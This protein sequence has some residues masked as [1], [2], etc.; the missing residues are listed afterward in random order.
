MSGQTRLLL[1]KSVVRRYFEGMSAPARGLVLAEEEQQVILL[2][3][4]E[5]WLQVK[6]RGNVY[7][8]NEYSE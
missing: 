5:M 6:A 7:T 2:L 1:D 3:R 8:F 4:D